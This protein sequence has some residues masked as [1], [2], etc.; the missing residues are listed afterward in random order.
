MNK[1]N[2]MMKTCSKC[3][4]SKHTKEFHKNSCEKDGFQRHC[5]QCRHEYSLTPAGNRR[6]YYSSYHLSNRKEKCSASR[7]YY[8]N[9]KEK[10]HTKV[11]ERYKVDINYKLSSLLRRRMCKMISRGQK[12]GSAVRDLGCSLQH[13]KLHLELFWDNGMSWGNYGEWV[14]DHILP[15]AS[16]DLSDREQLIEAVNYRN[17]QPLWAKDNL[18]KVSSDK[19]YI[20]DKGIN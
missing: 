3:H 18:A 4:K 10:I 5:V 14:I 16:F 11:K 19:I 13:L 2:G 9:N 7:E 6:E 15:L 12:A 20:N 8:L 17:L 1:D